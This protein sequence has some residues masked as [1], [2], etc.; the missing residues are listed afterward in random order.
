MNTN[1]YIHD[2][3]IV[4]SG[5]QAVSAIQSAIRS[6]IRPVVVPREPSRLDLLH[7]PFRVWD[8]NR[9][10]RAHAV[11]IAG[12]DRRLAPVY[13]DWLAH[14]RFGRLVTAEDS[15]RTNVAGVFAAG[16]EAVS[17]ALRWMRS[18]NGLEPVPVEPRELLAAA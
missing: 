3:V 7:R 6:G 18:A 16:S 2:M 12:G 10:L 17:D 9:E 5:A 15:T 11:V 8:G 1:T 13:R 4:G 14:D